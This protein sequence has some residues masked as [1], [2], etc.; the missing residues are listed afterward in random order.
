MLK[1]VS[2]FTG[3]VKITRGNNHLNGEHAEVNLNTLSKQIVR[4]VAMAVYR[5][6]TPEKKNGSAVD[7]IPGRSSEQRGS[8]YDEWGH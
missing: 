3:S 5:Y 4:R 8:Q 6:A 7:R 2:R 1:L